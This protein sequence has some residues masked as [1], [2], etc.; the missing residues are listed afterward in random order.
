VYSVVLAGSAG[1]GI[2]EVVAMATTKREPKA[3]GPGGRPRTWSE[4]SA[5]GAKI[6]AAA[7]RKNLRLQEVAERAGICSASLYDVVSG[8][9][10]SPSVA[11]AFRI[12]DALETT[13][14]RIF[15]IEPKAD[16]RAGGAARA[17]ATPHAKSAR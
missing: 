11:I 9:V 15:R 14:E 5:I 13:V 4:P 10:A 16:A 12:A 17:P 8:R 3:K 2:H 7:A 6:M 1:D